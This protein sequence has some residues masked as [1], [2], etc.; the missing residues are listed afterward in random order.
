M[1]S[2]DRTPQ[3][4]RDSQ[5][6]HAG[7][8]LVMLALVA[9]FFSGLY[10]CISERDV[11]THGWWSDRGPVVR[12]DTFP[13]D[14]SLC[15]KG[16]TWTELV[17]DFEWDHEA[18]TGYALIGAHE[19]AECLRCHNDR[20]PVQLFERQ[21]CGGCHEDIHLGLLGNECSSCHWESDWVP[22]GQIAEHRLTRF[23]LTGVHLTTPCWRCHL[24]SESGIFTLEDVRCASCHQED[25]AAAQ[26]PDHA[27]MG[28]VDS[29]QRCH[30]TTSW[31]GAG[32]RHFA[33][34]S[35]CQNCHLDD[36]RS[37]S[38]PLHTPDS[39]P[40]DCQ[41]CHF[42]E[43]WQ[44]AELDHPYPRV[45]I[46]EFFTCEQCHTSIGNFQTFSCTHCHWHD[47]GNEDFRHKGVRNYVWENQQ[48][49]D[50][51]PTGH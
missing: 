42:N 20:G 17:E 48:C 23:P 18:E 37:A 26:D 33:L 47:E 28:W 44:P 21:G 32:F 14:C 12:H 15:H 50:C 41:W 45:L 40:I 30:L 1:E 22:R 10:A 11:P 9:F 8:R 2:Q 46:H 51:H 39:F 13:E 24:G 31:G 16:S 38:R 36:Y 25:L 19:G 35:G 7:R 4:Q 29:C 49:V 43:S 6:E 3:C 5:A 34:T 27:L